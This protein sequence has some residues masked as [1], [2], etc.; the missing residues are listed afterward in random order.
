MQ[1]EEIQEKVRQIMV[2]VL[3]HERFTMRDDLAAGDVDGWNSLTHMMLIS[4]VEAGFSIK[5]KLKDLNKMR[6]IGDMIEMIISKL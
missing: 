3:K 4:E 1:R 6:N 5:F 2:S